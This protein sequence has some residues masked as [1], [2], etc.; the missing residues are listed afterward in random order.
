MG[1]RR[2]RLLLTL[3]V[4]MFRLQ[5]VGRRAWWS[6]TL[7]KIRNARVPITIIQ[8]LS[9]QMAQFYRSERVMSRCVQMNGS[10]RAKLLRFLFHLST[11]QPFRPIAIGANHP[12]SE[13]NFC[14]QR[15]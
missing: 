4:I 9:D 2:M 12:G 5:E 3:M 13:I 10:W 6:I 15:E 8:A 1:R 14:S 11:E 7:L